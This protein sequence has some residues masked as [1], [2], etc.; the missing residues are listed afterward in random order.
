MTKR[1]ERKFV[2]RRRWFFG[3][4]IFIGLAIIFYIT[5]HLWWVGDHYCWGSVQYCE[6]L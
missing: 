1:M 4:L 6:G 2:L 3:S 5:G